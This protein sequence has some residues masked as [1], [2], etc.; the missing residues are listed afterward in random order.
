M[1]PSQLSFP[2]VDHNSERV[3]FSMLQKVLSSLSRNHEHVKL[4]D[5]QA[6][7]LMKYKEGQGRRAKSTT[8]LSAV[9]PADLKI[10]LAAKHKVKCI[11]SSS[12]PHVMRSSRVPRNQQISEASLS[13]EGVGKG[14]EAKPTWS[15]KKAKPET[16]KARQ[17]NLKEIEG[18]FDEPGA[19]FLRTEKTHV[20]RPIRN[21][22]SPL[23]RRVTDSGFRVKRIIKRDPEPLSW[24]KNTSLKYYRDNSALLQRLRQQ[25]TGDADEDR[26]TIWK[27]RLRQFVQ[28][29]V[30]EAV[31]LHHV[32][33]FT[34]FLLNNSSS[35]GDK[36]MKT[37]VLE[38]CGLAP[39]KSE[40]SAIPQKTIS[41]SSDKH[42]MRQLNSSKLRELGQ[43]WKTMYLPYDTKMVRNR[44]VLEQVIMQRLHLS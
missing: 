25:L 4:Q 39:A 18:D 36:P 27:V 28:E 21:Y 40:P 26:A 41:M 9:L 3:N 34:D 10:E 23:K 43:P 13:V 8:M 22:E 7:L 19:D 33:L 38:V 1:E 20:S 29:Y 16:H 30:G 14:K 12:R 17:V 44:L 37:I 5:T 42:K 11:R 32:Q 6:M 35:I 24:L 15:L 31:E 2:S